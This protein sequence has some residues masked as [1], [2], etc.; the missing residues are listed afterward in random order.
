MTHRTRIRADRLLATPVAFLLNGLARIMGALLHRDHSMRPDNVQRIVVAKLIGMGSILQA[1]PLLKALKR[2]YPGCTITFVSLRS[3]RELLGRLDWVDEMLTLDDRTPFAMLSTTLR[4]ITGLIRR[5]AD[6]YF[7][8]ELYSAFASVLAL[9]AVTRNRLGF[10]RHSTAFKKGIYTHLVYFNT[11][12]PVRLLYLQLGRVAGV[13]SGEPDTIGPI[14]ID[15]SDRTE[16][17]SVLARIA[18]WG[19]EK[20][21]IVINPNASDLL[22]E[23]RWPDAHVIEAMTRLTAAGKSIVLIGSPS[24]RDYVQGLVERLPS[25][26]VRNVANS[27]GLLTLGG[28][29]AMLQGADCVL[30]NDSG[31]MHM[32]IALQRPTV[33]LFG[34]ANPE[35]YGQELPM[36]SIIYEQVFCSPCLYEADQPPCH[37][38]NVCMQRIMPARVVQSV[39]SGAAAGCGTAKPH[40]PMKDAPDG[41]PLGVVVRASLTPTAAFMD[42][43]RSAFKGSTSLIS[44]PVIDSRRA[45]CLVLAIAGAATVIVTFWLHAF[46][47]VP[48]HDNL[49]MLLGADRLLH[50]GRFYYDIFDPNPPLIFLLLEPVALLAHLTSVDV[51]VL[52]S[53]AVCLLIAWST[54]RITALL[55]RLF[56]SRRA[57]GLAAAFTYI[58]IV[59][60]LPGYQFGQR[61]HIATILFCPWLFRSALEG[62]GQLQSGEF[63]SIFE[64]AVAAI[65]VLIKPF[66]LLLPMGML[67]LRAIEHRGWRATLSRDAVVFSALTV[68]YLASI[69][70]LFPE[71]F[72]VA[73]LII[74]I[75]HYFDQRIAVVVRMFCLPPLVVVGA[76]I[77]G[78][79]LQLAD[80]SR[81]LLRHLGL[82]VAILFGCAVFQHKTWDYHNLP[83]LLLMPLTLALLIVAIWPSLIRMQA[84]RRIGA[85]ALLFGLLTVGWLVTVPWFVSNFRSGIAFMAEP[86]SHTLAE[87]AGRR[88]PVLAI[89][90]WGLDSVF[91]A[92]SLLD[93]QWSSRTSPQLLVPAI[94]ELSRGNSADHKR[95]AELRQIWARN[96]VTDLKRY[97]PLVIAVRTAD[98]HTAFAM[99]GRFNILGLLLEDSAFRR[100]WAAYHQERV[101]PNWT[102][103]V[104]SSEIK[105]GEEPKGRPGASDTRHA[106]VTRNNER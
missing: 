83:A 73:Q 32:S 104:R 77:M 96:I 36:V 81:T 55:L 45:Q 70:L 103:Y 82:A 69:T 46:Y 11:R 22:L 59:C 18:G 72:K 64:T 26:V 34:P 87:L 9:C 105:L 98:D 106:V 89:A 15:E 41:T 4:T 30:T 19:A 94:V 39:L 50:G 1:T 33:C 95:A 5:R 20:P 63:S 7:D 25:E 90:T 88:R 31:P 99:E 24:E 27:A 75:Y 66:F 67:L 85:I 43:M 74:E 86:F 35:H 78:E 71:Y 52:F 49:F 51:Y 28:L 23:R 62:H 65:G 60:F 58:T 2:T 10:Y 79:L 38:N 53:A 101:I 100:S 29:L 68:F 76:L 40:L 16:A 17:R 80:P 6:L 3:N 13:P 47:I 92:V 57:A 84:A 54:T 93:D 91:P 21:Y 102:F 8:L 44:P 14:R 37:G 97:R 48:N 12:M 42:C 61:E 56:E